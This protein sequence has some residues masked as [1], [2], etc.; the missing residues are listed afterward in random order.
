[1]DL[2]T[3]LH[4]ALILTYYI[5]LTI[6]RMPSTGLMDDPKEAKFYD[7][8]L[9]DPTNN[10]FTTF[11]FHY[12]S[13]DNLSSLNLI[14]T[15]HPRTLLFPSPSL[16]SLNCQSSKAHQKKEAAK[17]SESKRQDED[18]SDTLEVDGCYMQ[19]LTSNMHGYASSTQPVAS[20]TNHTRDYKCKASK[21]A[22]KDVTSQ[23]PRSPSPYYRNLSP[24]ALEALGFSAPPPVPL[25]PPTAQ[26]EWAQIL[27]RPL[28][29]IPH[30]YQSSKIPRRPSASSD[31]PFLTHSIKERYDR[32]TL[33]P[34]PIL[35][36]AAELQ[37]RKLNRPSKLIKIKRCYPMRLPSPSENSDVPAP[38]AL[39]TKQQSDVMCQNITPCMRRESSQS[40]SE[41]TPKE[42]S[43]ECNLGNPQG[44]EEYA[45]YD[46]AM[47]LS[48]TESEWLSRAQTFTNG[49]IN[50][51]QG[52]QIESFGKG[53][54][55]DDAEERALLRQQALDWYESA[56][57]NSVELADA[58]TSREHSEPKVR[59]G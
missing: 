52:E 33:S 14:P 57:G 31:T 8:L 39:P 10:P 48:L 38:L 56:A 54:N 41:P 18:D 55:T 16:L 51:R 23:V 24:P 43:S 40:P 9:I 20:L 34:S 47:P 27:N 59:R 1:M 50:S 30:E 36:T 15:S 22:D 3:S 35:K 19:N 13:W 58:D 5:Y 12:R 7:W 49:T 46:D 32:H 37:F 53:K 17:R 26:L 4:V 45:S 44:Y 42:C 21:N 11:K 29:E 6:V 25:L 28:P 2:C